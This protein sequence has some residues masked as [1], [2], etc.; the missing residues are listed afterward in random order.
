MR[1][2][3]LINR[4]ILYLLTAS[5]LLPSQAMSI[6][7]SGLQS[8]DSIRDAAHKHML[9]QTI[10]QDHTPVIEVGHLD[11]RLRLKACNKPLETFSPPGSRK[12]G[13]GTVGVRCSGDNPWSLYVPVKVSIMLPIVVAARELP[14]GK[15]L[16]ADDI[17]LEKRDITSIHRGY[18]EKTH[19]AIGKILKRSLRRG[20]IL[21]ASHAA[22]PQAIKKGSRVTI[23]A[24]SGA[25][26]IRMKGKALSSGARGERIQVQNLSSKRELDATVIS[27]GIVEVTM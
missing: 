8:H 17:Q 22:A 13:R 19:Y 15:I 5:C 3:L 1:M 25:I 2:T 4:H 16:T 12:K 9:A 23:V 24:N 6:A 14:R 21:T 18:L 26:A 11:S 10:N 20:Q 7:V 27:P